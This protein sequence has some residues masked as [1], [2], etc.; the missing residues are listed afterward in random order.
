MSAK[1][2]TARQL[3]E[4]PMIIVTSDYKLRV[5]GGKNM[6]EYLKSQG[7]K[8]GKGLVLVDAKGLKALLDDSWML[9]HMGA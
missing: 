4:N 7:T 9:R 8:P 3:A 5:K 1:P 6:A 2:L